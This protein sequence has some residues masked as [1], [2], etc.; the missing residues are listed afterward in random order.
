MENAIQVTLQA[1]AAFENELLAKQNVV[2]VA[3]G[4]KESEGTVTDEVAVVVLVK[5]KMSL[6][7]LSATDV[8]PRQLDGVRTDVIAVGELRAQQS[9]RL[10]FRP[11]IPGGVS[12]GHYRVTAGTLGA[13]VRH[14]ETGER[15]ILSN[16]HVLANSNDAAINDGIIQPG[17]I[18]GGIASADVIAQLAQFIPLRYVEEAGQPIPTPNPGTPT[19][20]P[21]PPGGGGTQPQP[22]GCL[23][24]MVGVMNLIASL[25]GSQNRVTT[26]NAASVSAQS[27]GPS[28]PTPILGTTPRFQSQS[29]DNAFDAALARPMSPSILSDEILGIGRVTGSMAPRLGQRVRKSGRTTGLTFGTVTLLNATVNVGYTTL[30]GE[31]TARFTGQVITEAMSQGGDSGS[32]IVD[33]TENR[34][35]GLLF[36]GSPLATIFTPIDIVLAAL[37]VTI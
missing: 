29:V 4:H 21:T 1:Q 18:D 5:E 23:S 17:M 14:R 11:T 8:I 33:A 34:A 13:V 25:M 26:T 28:M 36:A 35:V 32:L 7:A 22:N 3:V 15:L 19:P 10:R 24:A 9:P 6:R 30:R 12:I 2:G 37:N 20:T 31:R 16:N 27:A